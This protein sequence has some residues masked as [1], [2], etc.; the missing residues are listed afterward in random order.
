MSDRGLRVNENIR[1]REVRVIDENGEQLGVMIPREALRIARERG[2]DLVEVAPNA[3][4]PV[5][6]V[7]DYG[8]YMYE[9]SKKERESRKNQKT[10]KIKEVRISPKIDDHDFSV[11]VKNAVGFLQK[12]N[13]VKATVRFRG[14]EIVHADIGKKLLEDLAEFVQDYAVVERDP[15]VEGRNMIMILAPKQSE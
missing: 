2:L 11:R 13:K 9:K 10:V 3:R 12:G 8:K 14:R 1:A 4:P 7:M 6:R 15:K 5:C